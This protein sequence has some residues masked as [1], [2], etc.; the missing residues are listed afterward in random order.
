[1]DYIFMQKGRGKMETCRNQVLHPDQVEWLLMETNW[2]GGGY[3]VA[4]VNHSQF[5]YY[6]TFRSLSLSSHPFLVCTGLV[7]QDWC[8]VLSFRGTPQHVQWDPPQSSAG[9][10][11]AH[12]NPYDSGKSQAICFHY[13]YNLFSISFSV[14]GYHE[15]CCKLP[16][17]L[18]VLNLSQT[19]CVCPRSCKKKESLVCGT[20]HSAF[21]LLFRLFQHCFEWILHL[22]DCW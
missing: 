7:A 14:V 21:E 17:K 4:L 13:C 3:Y 8:C 5:Q 22:H 2:L 10:W 18:G 19:L 1:M 20:E 15:K 6:D 16:L 9:F 12:T 11:C